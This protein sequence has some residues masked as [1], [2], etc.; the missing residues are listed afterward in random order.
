MAKG[1]HLFQRVV[2]VANAAPGL[3][4]I[5]RSGQQLT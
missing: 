5:K 2:S 1:V 3:I 4:R